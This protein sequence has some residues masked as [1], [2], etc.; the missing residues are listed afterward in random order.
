MIKCDIGLGN[1]DKANQ[2]LTK[3]IN[4][5]EK[6]KNEANELEIQLKKAVEGYEHKSKAVF[7]QMFGIQINKC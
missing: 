4:Y 2:N 7:G 6:T 3:I 1:F 5:G